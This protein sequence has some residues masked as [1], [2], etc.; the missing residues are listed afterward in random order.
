ML[1]HLTIMYGAGMSDSNAH[2]YHNLPVLLAGG[3]AGSVKGGRH[4][5]YVDGTWANLL[6]TVMDKAGVPIDRIGNSTGRL[7]IEALSGI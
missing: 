1:D 7:D 6:V 2:D 5:K 4:L 3:G